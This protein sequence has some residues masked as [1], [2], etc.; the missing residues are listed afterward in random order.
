[1]DTIYKAYCL[2]SMLKDKSYHYFRDGT[3]DK[4]MRMFETKSRGILGTLYD[5]TTEATHIIDNIYLGNSVNAR[6]YYSL[7]KLNIGLIVNITDEIPNYFEGSFK[8]INVSI[9][10]ING[11]KILNHLTPVTEEINEF[12]KEYPDKKVLIHCFMGASRSASLLIAYLM[13]YHDFSLTE[14]LNYIKDKRE[15]VN[16]NVDFYKQL[17]EYEELLKLQQPQSI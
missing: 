15:I 3:S 13:R 4:T 12:V 17:I 1:M 10:D 14:A 5:L 9:K 2:G 11:S 8:Y 7:K 6:E 16:L